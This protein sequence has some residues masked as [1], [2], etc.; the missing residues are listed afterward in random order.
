[1]RQVGWATIEA[2]SEANVGFDK[3][4]FGYRDVDGSAVHNGRTKNV[5]MAAWD[6]GDV[7]G[8]ALWQP[9][10]ELP[11]QILFL[12]NGVPQATAFT[13]VPAAVYFPAVSLFDGA[14]AAVNLGPVFTHPPQLPFEWASADALDRPLAEFV[15]RAKKSRMAEAARATAAA[16]AALA[17]S[18]TPTPMEVDPVE[19]SLKRPRA[20]EEPRSSSDS[21][22]LLPRITAVNLLESFPNTS[23]WVEGKEDVPPE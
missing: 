14:A 8:C 22:S 17:P 3:H 16:A 21:A 20:E 4:S 23:F 13:E 1:L 9:D 2:N 19:T 6:T 12:K 15:N 10:A 11:G 5:G 18:P 7:I